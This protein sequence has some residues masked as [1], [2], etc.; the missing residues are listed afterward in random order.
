M[1]VLP[2]QHDKMINLILS[3]YKF[4]FSWIMDSRFF[5]LA[6]K[7]SEWKAVVSKGRVCLLS[8]LKTKDYTTM[9][10][11]ITYPMV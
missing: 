7:Q 4:N 6:R 5:L 8:T 3:F 10:P 9:F 2:W 11:S 1:S